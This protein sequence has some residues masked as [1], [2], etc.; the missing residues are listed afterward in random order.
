MKDKIKAKLNEHIDRLLHKTELTGED[1]AILR[2]TLREIKFEE[3]EAARRGE[4]EQKLQ[5]LTKTIFSLPGGGF[6]G[7]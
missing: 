3:E 1:Y 2:D 5:E 4:W 6:G 7:H